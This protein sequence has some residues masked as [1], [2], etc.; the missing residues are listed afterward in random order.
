MSTQ[1]DQV[2]HSVPQKWHFGVSTTLSH[3]DPGA[4]GLTQHLPWAH[5]GDRQQL[6]TRSKMRKAGIPRG[7]PKLQPDLL[8]HPRLEQL[9][10]HLQGWQ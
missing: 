5:T 4:G 2:L 7:P 8:P 9:C 3:S 1:A 6:S 10:C